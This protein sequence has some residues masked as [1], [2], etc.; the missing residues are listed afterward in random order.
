MTK[1]YGRKPSG[2]EIRLM[3]FVAGN[4][5][6]SRIA[7]Q[8]LADICEEELQ[9]RC[10]MEV[11][12]VFTNVETAVRHNILLTPTLLVMGSDPPGYVVGS[13]DDRRKVLDV[14]GL[15]KEAM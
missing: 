10:R 5:P 4:E 6:N 13:L 1:E 15:E 7:R 14:L 2:E 11:V 12:D 3:L 8:N 9:G